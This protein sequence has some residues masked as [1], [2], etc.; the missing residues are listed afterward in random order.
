MRAM[1]KIYSC[2]SGRTIA[3]VT[4]DVCDNP[5]CAERCNDAVRAAGYD[6]SEQCACKAGT[7]YWAR[8]V[9]YAGGVVAV[10]AEMIDQL[11]EIVRVYRDVT[12]EY[13][14]Q[15]ECLMNSVTSVVA[16]IT[17]LPVEPIGD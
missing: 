7:A 4:L 3:T 1:Y 17:A 2:S 16:E 9:G 13:P 15:R 5:T 10:P 8:L 6:P 12:A 11:K 14:A